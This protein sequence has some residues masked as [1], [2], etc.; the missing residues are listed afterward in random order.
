[1]AYYHKRFYTPRG[2]IRDLAEVVWHLPEIMAMLRTRRINRAFSEKVMLV[3]TSINDC[4]YCAYGHTNAALHSGVT[5]DEIINLMELKID[6]FPPEQA[7]ALAFAR[8]YA[9]T[10]RKS[11][12]EA[13]QRFQE[14][15]GPQISQDI[16]NY[17][18]L[19]TLG[20]LSGNTADAFISRLKGQPAKDSHFLNELI[21]FV[22]FAPVIL[23]LLIIMR[24]EK[25]K[26]L[27]AGL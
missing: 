18:R 8:H 15:Y 23:P 5:E 9:E 13:L 4:R 12:P 2:F 22:L 21:L 17:M 10:G 3:I 7:V 27:Q 25:S 20:N 26:I 11:D 16:L 24:H 14:Y 6:Q 19:I 1:M